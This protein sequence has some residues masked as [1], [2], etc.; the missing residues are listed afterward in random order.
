MTEDERRDSEAVVDFSTMSRKE[1]IR[2]VGMAMAGVGLGVA[3]AK[4]AG[5]K[6]GSGASGASGSADHTG[7]PNQPGGSHH[8]MAPEPPPGGG[9]RDREKAGKRR[10]PREDGE[11][12][13]YTS[14]QG[15]R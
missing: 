4:D 14:S 1:F 11:R 7:T 2:A 8:K 13:T 15:V 3:V 10:S 5:A 12:A 6:G 9:T